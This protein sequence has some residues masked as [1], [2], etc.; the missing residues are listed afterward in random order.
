MKQVGKWVGGYVGA[1]VGKSTCACVCACVGV[2]NVRPSV[3]QCVTISCLAAPNLDGLGLRPTCAVLTFEGLDGDVHV[4]AAALL[5]VA[6][7]H[8]AEVSGADLLVNLQIRR[9]LQQGPANMTSFAL[10]SSTLQTRPVA[11]A[12]Q[13]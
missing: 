4:F 2:Q 13:G 7:V 8:D 3:F 12:D 10:T 6:R 11:P 9:V 5:V 1:C